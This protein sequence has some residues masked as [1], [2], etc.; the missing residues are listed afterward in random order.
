VTTLPRIP[1]I[2]AL[3]LITTLLTACGNDDGDTAKTE[4]G[5]MGTMS[6]NIT[7]APLDEASHLFVRITGLELKPKN[8][9]SLEFIFCNRHLIKIDEDCLNQTTLELDLMTLTGKV[10]HALSDKRAIPAQQYNWIRLKLDEANPGHIKLTSTGDTEYPLTIPSGAQTGLK[11]NTQ[12]SLQEGHDLRLT[13]DFDLRKSVHKTGNGKYMLRPTL[14]LVDNS[15]IGHLS[16]TVDS[17]LLATEDCSPAIYLYEYTLPPAESE[18]FFWPIA[19]D[20]HPDNHELITTTYPV[21]N[22]GSGIYEYEIG[23]ITE[24]DYFVAFTCSAIDDDPAEDDNINIHLPYPVEIEAGQETTH[25]FV[26][27]ILP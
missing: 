10:S 26:T 19:D 25:N 17:S 7:D 27:L 8:G 14:R 2:S 15:H 12:L 21:Y 24:G 13:I 1:L 11:I 9:K 4:N 23:F 16:G 3:L 6:I 20:I 18:L 5:P 22:K